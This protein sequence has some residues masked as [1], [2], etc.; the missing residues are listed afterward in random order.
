MIK[1][2]KHVYKI[3]DIVEVVNPRFVERIGYPL[4]REQ[5]RKE[6]KNKGFERSIYEHF[7]D[8]IHQMSTGPEE[9]VSGAFDPNINILS[10]SPTSFYIKG[11]KLNFEKIME[12][13][14]YHIMLKKFGGNLKSIHTKEIPELM[15]KRF[16]VIDKKIK[17]TG[18]Y[19]SSDVDCSAYLSNPKANIILSLN[20]IYD[21]LK[22]MNL[23][24]I[25]N[26]IRIEAP[27]V[28]PIEWSE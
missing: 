11:S 1:K 12:D 5:V 8:I 28:I 19:I 21:D 27:N 24:I 16:H 4:S 20:P 26:F 22:G 25:E 13:L 23:S 9:F 2:K 15:N 10:M 6:L 7:T 17:Y 14:T 18:N 3:G